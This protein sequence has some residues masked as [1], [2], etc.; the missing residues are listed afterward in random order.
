[1]RVAVADLAEPVPFPAAAERPFPPDASRR[2]GLRIGVELES[3]PASSR[4]VAAHLRM[5]LDDRRA[6]AVSLYTDS[7]GTVSVEGLDDHAFGWTFGAHG[8]PA[9][10]AFQ[11]RYVVNVV[12]QIPDDMKALT[13]ALRADVSVAT[14]RVR[15]KVC[16]ACARTAT[17]FAVHALPASNAGLRAPSVRLC[18]AADIERFSR[19]STP[20]AAAVQ[21]RFTDLLAQAWEHAGIAPHELDLERG[22]DGQAVVFPSGIDESYVIPR[23][24]EGL[25]RGLARINAG[26]DE[27]GVLRIRTALYRGHVAWADNGWVGHPPTAVRRLVDSP[28]LRRSLADHPEAGLA[29]IISDTIYQDIVAQGFGDLPPGA[30]LPVQVD[31]PQKNFAE[32]AWLHVPSVP[33]LPSST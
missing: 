22:G 20:E 3:Q 9:S 8:N 6:K 7:P 30:F 24:V 12:I 26:R 17:E 31:L 25:A 27:H 19:F 10:G 14:G 2:I 23:L 33:N 21:E 16:H 13:G 4:L 29:L 18:F 11:N 5:C 15:T 1:M 28:V 32:P